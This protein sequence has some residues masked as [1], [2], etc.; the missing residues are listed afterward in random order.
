MKKGGELKKAD[1]VLGRLCKAPLNRLFACVLFLVVGIAVMVQSP[2][3]ANALPCEDLL[4]LKLKGVTI[5]LA[6]AVPAGGFSVPESDSIPLPIRGRNYKDLPSFCRVAA[7]VRPVEGSDI[8]I[9]VWMPATAWNG[10]FLGV[11][12]G[13]W[14]GSINYAGLANGITEGFAT[15]STDTGHMGTGGDARFASGHPEKLIDFGYRAVHEMTLKAK[16][17]T[18]AFYGSKPHR[19]YWN[20]C[21]TGGKDGLMEAQRFPR[22]YNGVVAGDP[23]NFW[24]RLM[25]GTLWPSEATLRNGASYISESKYALIHQAALKACDRLDGVAD[26]IIGDPTACHFDPKVLECKGSAASCLTLAQEEAAR[27]IYAG[28]IDP[29]RGVQIFP[30]LEPGSELRWGILAGGPGPFSIADNYFKYVVFN[31]PNWDFRTLNLERDVERADLLDAKILNATDPDLIAFKAHGGKLI[32]Y[33]GW[34]DPIIAPLESVNYYKSV[35]AAMG[36]ERKTTDFMR[37]FMV[38]GMMHCGGGPGPDTF[39]KL[40]AVVRWVEQGIAPDKIVASH[41]THGVVDMTRPL[42]PYPKMARWNGSGSTN[43]AANFVCVRKGTAGVFL[44]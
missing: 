31:N 21:S 8:R 5:T 18:T 20:G 25:F 15:A 9:E 35:V 39:D 1:L 3:P 43:D 38:P 6:R 23:A 28:P 42:C 41:S 16:T 29:R 14:A 11:G 17:I 22:D 40:G 32:L 13:G 34:S 24:T 2:S 12:N 4:H 36:S 19:S 44:H 37:L 10:R 27:K 30:G 26:G 33:H 7:T